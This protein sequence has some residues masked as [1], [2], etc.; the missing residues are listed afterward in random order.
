MKRMG[1]IYIE[2]I[3]WLLVVTL[4]SP[5]GIAT[6]TLVCRIRD[7]LPAHRAAGKR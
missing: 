4:D 6:V 2:E 1:F 5:P 3:G 7:S